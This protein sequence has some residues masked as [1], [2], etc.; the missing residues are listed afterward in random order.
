MRRV[1]VFISGEVVGVFFRSFIENNAIRLGIKG[2]VR[3]IEDDEIEA[4]FEGKD[5][6]IDKIIEL[7]K[8]G[9]ASADVESIEI[10]EGIY[11]GEFLDFRVKS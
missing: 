9:P 4:V 3:N 2:W 10:D 7:C 1:H 5:H 6:A 8:D 11:S